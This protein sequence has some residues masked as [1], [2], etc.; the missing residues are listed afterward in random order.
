MACL[1]CSKMDCSERRRGSRPRRL[2]GQDQDRRQRAP[3]QPGSGA[4]A[5][6]HGHERGAEDQPH[7]PPPDRDR[8][9]VRRRRPSPGALCLALARF[10]CCWR[11]AAQLPNLHEGDASHR[12]RLAARRPAGDVRQ[13]AELRRLPRAHAHAAAR[14]RLPGAR[15][16]RRLRVLRLRPLAPAADGL[17][18]EGG[19]DAPRRYALLPPDTLDSLEGTQGGNLSAR[20]RSR[21]CAGR[22]ALVGLYDGDAFRECRTGLAWPLGDS[23]ARRAPEGG[24]RREAQAAPASLVAIDAPLRGAGGREVLVGA[25]ACRPCSPATPV[26]VKLVVPMENQRVLLASRPDGWVSEDNFRIESVPL[27]RPRDGEVLVKNLW[28]SLDPYMRGRMNE[29]KS[30][31]A[32]QE[33]GEVMIGGTVGEVVESKQSEVRGGRQGARHARLAAVRPVRRRGAEQGR[34]RA[35]CRCRPTSACSAC[36]A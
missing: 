16:P 31:A 27:P 36:R 5:R 32:K 8:A 14:R 1:A 6:R 25:A 28:L 20:R 29:G 22:S 21:R 35:A 34:R 19:R 23:R 17:L 9:A 7:L 30:Y 2:G 24:V 13:H 18:L 11:S 10:C 4:A 15:A 12:S 26:P 3:R 33:I